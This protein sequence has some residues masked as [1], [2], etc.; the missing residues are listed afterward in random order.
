[1]RNYRDKLGNHEF[2]QHEEL[3]I[4]HCK[5]LERIP[6]D[7]LDIFMCVYIYIYIFQLL[8]YL[9]FLKHKFK[10]LTFLKLPIFKRE[11]KKFQK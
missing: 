5:H 2:E 11:N 3:L 4:Q 7:I 10:N 8:K 6:K 9:P 1:M